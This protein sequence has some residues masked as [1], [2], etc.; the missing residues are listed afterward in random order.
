M[1]WLGV[2]ISAFTEFTGF[3]ANQPLI[4]VVQFLNNSPPAI[5]GLD[6]AA[7]GDTHQ[8]GVVA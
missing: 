2:G 7:L 3:S 8:A 1:A 4:R 5:D 6:V